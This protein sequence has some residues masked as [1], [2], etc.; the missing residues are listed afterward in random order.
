MRVLFFLGFSNP[1]PGAAWSRIHFFANDLAVKGHQVDVLGTFSPRFLYKR[2]FMKVGKVYVYNIIFNVGS[3]PIVSVFDLLVSLIVS[4]LFLIVKRP[5]IAVASLPSMSSSGLGFVTACFLL[6]TRLVIDYRDE[7]EEAIVK[8]QLKRCKKIY[9]FFKALMSSIYTK[10]DL[11]VTVTPNFIY[12]LNSRGVKNVKLVPNGADIKIFKPYDRA[13]T[14]K[15]IEIS[16]NDFVI[17]YSGTIGG[18][19]RLDTVVQAL[20]KLS[21]KISDTKLLIVGWGP[22]LTKIIDVANSLGIKDKMLYLGVKSKKRDLAEIISAADVGIIPYDDNLL[23]KNSL[24]AKFFEFCACGIPAVATVYEDS[25]L[26]KLIKEHKVGLTVPPMDEKKLAEAIYW[27]YKNKPYRKT[28][29]KRA[30][31]LIE[32]R[33]DRNKIAEE[34]LDLVKALV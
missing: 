2:G 34:F 18:Y 3:N 10:S 19:Y 30:R 32:E 8:A 9:P 21:S 29:S 12:S 7:W 26:A 24:P 33:F 23:W 14:R 28:A 17:V 27:I 25:I 15:K 13:A 16:E 4:L 6:R 22:D 5:K 20:A 1:F 11:V 31:A